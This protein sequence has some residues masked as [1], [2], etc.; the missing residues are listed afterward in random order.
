MTRRIMLDRRSLLTLTAGTAGAFTL[1][2]CGGREG[3]AGKGGGEAGKLEWIESRSAT[4]PTVQAVNAVI[5]RYKEEHPDF[6]LGITPM[7]DRPSFDERIRLLASSNALPAMFDA[8]PEPFFRG[9]VDSGVI[10]NIGELYDK[11]GIR[12]SFFPISIEYPTWDDGS[13]HLITLNANIEY[14]WYN[15]KYFAEVGVEPPATLDELVKVCEALRAGGYTPIALNG[16]DGWPYYRYLAMIPFRK[17]GNKFIEGLVAGTEKMDS[18]IG[19]QAIE[20]LQKMAPYFQDGF[21]NTAYTDANDLFATK[22]VAMFYSSTYGMANFL[23]DKGDLDADFG[24]FPIPQVGSDDAMPTSNGFANSGPGTAVLADAMTEEMEEFLKYFFEHYP[25]MAL[26]EFHVIP[27]IQP[28]IG[29][30]IPEIYRQVIEDIERVETYAKV[31]DVEL[32]PSVNSVLERE[33]SALLTGQG[34]PES[35]ARNV[36][37]AIARVTQG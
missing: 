28:K 35:F 12:D 36:D 15:R 2:A 29:D 20:F 14:F 30:D 23:D 1:S 4:E 19:R 21:S 31:W 3:S 27:C 6:G 11:L 10:A 33:S 17:T 9:I 7:P 25:Q 24:Y 32:D 5:A 22:K 16:Q 26:D 34:T 13:L 8:D 37:E 18:E